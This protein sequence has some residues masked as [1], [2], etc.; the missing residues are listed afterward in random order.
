M[1]S[2]DIWF[3][4]LLTIGLASGLLL[5]NEAEDRCVARGIPQSEC[6]WLLR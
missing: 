5:I 4:I 2:A 6:R 3:L 1:N